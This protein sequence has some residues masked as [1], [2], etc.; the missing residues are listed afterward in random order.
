MDVVGQK[1]SLFGTTLRNNRQPESKQ[2]PKFGMSS[3][4]YQGLIW[5][6]GQSWHVKYQIVWLYVER[7]L[8]VAG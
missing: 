2:C 4:L 1:V 7:G 3:A 6:G 5:V 8:L